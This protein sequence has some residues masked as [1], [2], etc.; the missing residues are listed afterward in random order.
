MSA[1]GVGSGAGRWL[2]VA[3][4]LVVVATVA[5]AVA[6]MGTPAA[7][8]EAKLDDRRVRDLQRIGVAV[9]D[10]REQHDALPPDLATLAGR[11]GQRLAIADPVSGTPYAYEI[12]GERSYRLCAVFT[13]D[14]AEVLADV[15][16]S[17]EWNHGAGRQC[18][19]RRSGKGG[20]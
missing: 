10:Y 12:T 19:E 7:R 1:D 3:A 4:G 15:R 17:S 11:P 6:V 9:D 13:T 5:A 2:L 14:T 20:S 16:W 18:F 8:R